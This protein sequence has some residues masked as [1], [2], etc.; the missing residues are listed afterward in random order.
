MS[1]QEV[2]D[3]IGRPKSTYA[4]YEDKF[5]K[6]HLPMDLVQQ[7]IP[8][9]RDKNVRPDELLRLAGVAEPAQSALTEPA[10]SPPRITEIRPTAIDIG[11]PRDLPVLGRAVG[12][13]DAWFEFNGERIDTIFRPP[14][15][16]NV[17]DAYALFMDGESMIP[18]FEPGDTLYVHPGR[19]VRAGHYVV[20]QLR[21]EAPGDPIRALVKRLVSL[22]ANEAVVKSLNPP[23][24]KPFKIARKKILHIHKI[25]LSGEG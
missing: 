5:K 13:D 12:G 20:V 24:S 3:A 23:E 1:V 14:L 25:S 21:P 22:S 8:V 4:S 6:P 11:R 18:K 7:L 2:A 19:P 16:D 17:R 15:L 10:S 9:W